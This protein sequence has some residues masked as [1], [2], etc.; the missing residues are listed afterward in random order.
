VQQFADA[1]LKAGIEK[2]AK[3]LN[4]NKGAALVVCGSN[5]VN[6]QVVVNAINE[7]DWRWWKNHR[8][9]TL[10]TARVLMQILQNW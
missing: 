10:N 6:V 9:V 4:E 1:K 7:A 8:L 5:D 3:E 2:A